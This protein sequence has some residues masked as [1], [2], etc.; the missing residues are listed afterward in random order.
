MKRTLSFLIMM[1]ALSIT[2]MAQ[3]KLVM[4]PADTYDWGNSKPS[5]SPLKAKVKIYNKGNTDL[6]VKNVRPGC[7]CTTAPLDKNTISPNEFATLDVTLNISSYSGEVTKGIM[8]ESNDPERPSFNYFI[9]TNVERPIDLFPKYMVFDQLYLGEAAT[10]KVIVRNF[11]DKPIKI[12]D[13][14]LTPV[15][16]KVNIKK[17][18]IVPAKGDLELSATFAPAFTGQN[19]ISVVI[20]TDNEEVPEVRVSGWGNCVDKPVDTKAPQ[21]N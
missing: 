15:N 8:I 16:I 14:I 9:K 4:D 5:Q 20:K 13:M 17:G 11:T 3:P 10:G 18:D 12:V 6:V 7:G 19:Q 1:L 2:A 21:K